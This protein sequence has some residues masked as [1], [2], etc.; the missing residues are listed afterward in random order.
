MYIFLVRGG[1]VGS[2]AV[3][4]VPPQPTQGNGNV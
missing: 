4:A 1:G 3:T 2:T